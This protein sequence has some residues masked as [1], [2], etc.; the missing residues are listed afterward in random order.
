VD[1]LK[2]LPKGDD[3]KAIRR[4]IFYKWRKWKQ[5]HMQKIYND[6][7]RDLY[8]WVL[9]FSVKHDTTRECSAYNFC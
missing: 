1:E 7:D 5:D 8:S 6:I 2:Q 3:G 4:N 9:Y